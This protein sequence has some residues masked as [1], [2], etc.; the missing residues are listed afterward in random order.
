MM[1]GDGNM[2]DGLSVLT[3]ENLDNFIPWELQQILF[4]FAPFLQE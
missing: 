1:I 4:L 3:T 2:L